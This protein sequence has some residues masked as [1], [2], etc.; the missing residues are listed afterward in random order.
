MTVVCEAWTF[1]PVD[2]HAWLDAQIIVGGQ[3][4]PD[5]LREVALASAFGTAGTAAE[6]LDAFQV[7]LDDWGVWHDECDDPGVI[8]DRWAHW[9]VV[10]MARHVTAAPR[11]S[12]ASHGEL[13]GWLPRARSGWDAAAERTAR[14][15][16]GQSLRWLVEDHGHEHLHAPLGR[17]LRA[18]IVS[19]APGGGWLP[20]HTITFY[21]RWLDETRADLSE[22]AGEAFDDAAGALA[23]RLDTAIQRNAALRM[24]VVI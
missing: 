6:Y 8:R 21:R 17:A 5:K 24:V 4:S 2:F 20:L 7:D 19:S 22:H 9:Y 10:S 23:A 15:L 13:Q 12:W 18:E 14:L 16:N 1:D 3:F 11:L